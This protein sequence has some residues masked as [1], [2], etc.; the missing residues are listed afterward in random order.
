MMVRLMQ[1]SLVKIRKF[2]IPRDNGLE[3]AVGYHLGVH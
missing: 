3:V 1:I 2:E